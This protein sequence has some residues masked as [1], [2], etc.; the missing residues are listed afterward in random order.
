MLR[1]DDDSWIGSV[2]NK[3]FLLSDD[4]LVLCSLLP[5]FV[6]SN[7]FLID[8]RSKSW[9][10]VSSLC[11]QAFSSIVRLNFVE[12]ALQ[13]CVCG[14][15]IIWA[16][17]RSSATALQNAGANPGCW[18]YITVALPPVFLEFPPIRS[19]L[20]L[21]SCNDNKTTNYHIFLIFIQLWR[22][23]NHLKH[24]FWHTI[25]YPHT[26]TIASPQEKFELN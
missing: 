21:C 11:F 13:R 22:S 18:E 5:L 23:F 1:N 4:F 16:T 19:Y 14:A 2:S 12:I 26:W 8:F 10:W 7:A 6:F 9:S 15:A 20:L 24:I 17:L 25:K 3:H